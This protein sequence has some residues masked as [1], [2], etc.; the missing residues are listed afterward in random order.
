MLINMCFLEYSKRNIAENFSQPIDY[1]PLSRNARKVD[2]WSPAPELQD[3][4]V[5]MVVI[6]GGG[7]FRCPGLDTWQFMHDV[8]T[9]MP[10]HVPIVI[11]GMGIN[12]H[13]RFDRN[14]GEL[15]TSLENRPNVLIGLRDCFYSRY[16]P[17]A[18]CMRPEFDASFTIQHEIGLYVHH[19]LDIP[20]DHPRMSNQ[21]EGDPITY[22]GRVIEFLGSCETVLTTTYHGAYWATLLKR[23]VIVVSPFSNKFFGFKH[24]P[25]IVQE[26]RWVRDALPFARS[27][28]HALT[29]CRQA[30]REFYAAVL[31][32]QKTLVA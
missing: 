28:E 11:W 15:L 30:N 14:Y 18:S 12:D 17:C 3:P 25:A 21:I 27:Y 5:S 1:F 29:E 10:A 9:A 7:A 24:E 8:A 20:L 4:D 32:L 19:D 22:F 23:K 31:D 16:V 6:G 13:G 2:I 26:P